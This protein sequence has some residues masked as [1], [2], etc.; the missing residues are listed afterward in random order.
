MRCT[1]RAFILGLVSGLLLAAAALADNLLADK[2]TTA[3]SGVK[4]TLPKGWKTDERG[5]SRNL[6]LARAPT[7][8]KD[9]TGEFQTLFSL[10]ADTI[11]KLDG[12]AQQ[13]AVAKKC[14]NYHAIEEPT[15]ITIGGADGVMFGGTFTTGS[16][17]L[18]SRQYLLLQNGRV[19]ILTFTALDSA[20]PNYAKAIEACAASL[21]LPVK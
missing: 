7:S 18:R 3:K 21:T 6:L 19:Y 13:A 11:T 14:D 4:I 5:G 12:R 8:D 9:N 15:P 2:S 17:K 10:D 16:V 1:K 20:W